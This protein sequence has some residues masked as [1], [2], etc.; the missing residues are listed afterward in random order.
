MEDFIDGLIGKPARKALEQVGHALMA[1]I[2]AGA[3]AY[4]LAALGLP[5]AA[6]F[7]IGVA[8]SI[9]GVPY[10]WGFFREFTQNWGDE[11]DERTF[12]QISKLPINMNMVLD[13]VFYAV[14]GVLL[15]PLGAWLGS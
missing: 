15:S 9:I 3:A 14:G 12:L 1:G 11:P 8:I 7:G 13:K 2:P 10:A 5:F 6:A 4:G